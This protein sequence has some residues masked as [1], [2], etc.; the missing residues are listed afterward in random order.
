MKRHAELRWEK[1]ARRAV[2]VTTAAGSLLSVILLLWLVD[3]LAPPREED[4]HAA[5][6]IEVPL[7]APAVPTLFVSGTATVVL[8]RVNGAPVASLGHCRTCRHEH[9]LV[10]G[11]TVVCGACRQPMLRADSAEVARGCQRPAIPLRV[12]EAVLHISAV[13]VQRALDE[14]LQPAPAP[15]K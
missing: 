3:T 15:I 14:L 11:G 5:S 9:P 6:D 4:A 7:P 10:R 1:S 2:I 12:G 13:D 8:E